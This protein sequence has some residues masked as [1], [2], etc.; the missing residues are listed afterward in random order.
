MRLDKN[1]IGRPMVIP[2]ILWTTWLGETPPDLVKRCIETQQK[3]AQDF[4]YEHR[5]LDN[6]YASN[7]NGYVEE[8]LIR[9]DVKGYVKASDWLRCYA[10]L[11]EGGIYIDADM[12]ILP[13][14]NFDHL[15]NYKM[16]VP[17]DPQGHFGNAGFGAEVGHPLLKHYLDRI[18][19]NFKGEG[20]LVYEPGIRAFSD[21]FYISDV[22]EIKIL[23]PDYFFPYNHQT[24]KEEITPN[25]LVK[26]YYLDSWIDK[27]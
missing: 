17:K 8:C 18:S 21:M 27:R 1:M 26:H 23:T 20:E 5:I 9:K 24:G 15:L 14:K 2:K 11:E 7:F 13:G 16:F 12:E 25:T 4:G 19:D 3:C 6:D 10:L 22:S